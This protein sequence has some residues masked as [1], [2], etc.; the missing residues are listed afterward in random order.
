MLGTVVDTEALLKTV[1]VALVAGVGLT[2]TFAL[3]LRSFIGFIE[4][5]AEER[6][7]LAY[8]LAAVASVALLGFVALI[9]LGMIV[10]AS[11]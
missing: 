1:A 4:M 5:R 3:M 8:A 6:P 10:M 2:I 7:L 9:V 11:E